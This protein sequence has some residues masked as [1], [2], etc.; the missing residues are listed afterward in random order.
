M[1]KTIP[2]P[3]VIIQA[4]NESPKQGGYSRRPREKRWQREVELTQ[5]L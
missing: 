2:E 3:T 1:E 5:V 4:R